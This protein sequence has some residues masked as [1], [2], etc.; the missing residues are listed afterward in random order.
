MSERIKVVVAYDGAPFA[1]WQSQLHG[2]TVQD[3]MEDALKQI[4]GE[5]VRVHGAG[6]TDTGVHAI[7]QCAHFDLKTQS[8]KPE[9]LQAALNAVLPPT[10]RILRCHP[11][12]AD[13]HARFDARGK[14]YRYRVWNAPVLP[15]LE[16][17]R[18]WHIAS[19]LN[20]AVLD[21]AL[22]EFDGRHDFAAF[23][24]NRGIKVNETVR[25]VKTRRMGG[26]GPCLT[27]EFQGDGFLYKMVRM[28]VG[29]VVLCA[30][31]KLAGTEI[32][33][34]LEQGQRG[35]SSLVAPAAGLFLIR[36]RY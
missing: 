29:A 14:V 20:L 15:P 4:T 6:R 30:Q 19:P 31:G 27:M 1:G 8:F 23:A 9:R 3:R 36:V 17:G 13:F 28:M 16:L 35:G 5:E 26:K 10:I 7:G 12:S 21:A 2:K 18:A 11:V 25:T 33:L 22:A 34:R 24:A 32:S